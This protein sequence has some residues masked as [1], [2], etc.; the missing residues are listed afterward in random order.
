MKTMLLRVCA[1][2]LVGLPG[3]AFAADLPARNSAP[4]FAPPPPVFTWAGAYIGANLGYAANN[5]QTNYGYSYLPGNGTGNF[6]DFFGNAYDNRFAS[7]AN[8]PANVGGLNAV[9]SALA[10]GVIPASLGSSSQSAFAAGGQI[11][12]N[13]QTG[14]F[15]YGGEADL[16]WI[17]A[18]GTSG[19]SATIPGYT[20]AGWGKTSVDWMATARLRAGYAVDRLLVFGTAGLAFGGTQASSG[21][22]GSD[23]TTTDTFAGSSSATR[24]G[25]TAGGGAEY[26]FTDHWIGRVEGLYYDLG[27]VDYAVAAQNAQT[28]A[29]GVSVEA[30]HRFDGALARVGLSYKF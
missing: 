9:Q 19:F 21:S 12:Y 11:G 4:A 24:V 27:S 3:C 8:G 25:W 22:V 29:E 5:D 2:A 13:W 15:V 20:N 10:R 30:H 28:L 17:G 23:G 6:S 26:A 1:A 18:G 16:S 14:S 7:A